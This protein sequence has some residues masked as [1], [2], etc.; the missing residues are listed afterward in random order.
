MAKIISEIELL[1]AVTNSSFIKRGLVSGIEGVKYDFHAS[2]KILKA[3]FPVTDTAKFTAT[4][5]AQLKIEPMEVVF[6]LTEESLDLPSNMVAHLSPKRK[7]SHAG[8]ITLGGL[9]VDPKYKGRLLVGLLNVTSTPFQVIPG[10]KLIAATFYKLDENECPR[11]SSNGSTE[12]IEDFPDELIAV[13]GRYEPVGPNK[14]QE[15]INSLH[16]TI[17]KLEEDLRAHKNWYQVHEARPRRG[18]HVPDRA[19][20]AHGGREENQ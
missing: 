17:K 13:M 16:E 19:S 7:L 4:E 5:L 3:K 6:I 9:S 12:S 1:S 10:K 18:K 20:D 14:M 8:I 15:S 2:T 11:D